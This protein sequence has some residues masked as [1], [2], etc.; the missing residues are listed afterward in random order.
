[1]FLVLELARESLATGSLRDYWPAFERYGTDA[2]LPTRGLAAV[3]WIALVPLVPVVA[4]RRRRLVAQALEG[5]VRAVVA[6]VEVST[7]M[8]RGMEWLECKGIELEQGR[9]DLERLLRGFL[10]SS[11]GDWPNEPAGEHDDADST[12]LGSGRGGTGGAGVTLELL[13]RRGRLHEE[14]VE[15][16]TRQRPGIAHDD[17]RGSR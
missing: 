16:I 11:L 5:V 2:G 3:V 7:A 13:Q 10:S 9:A 1:M 12:E 6:G 4:A 14:G 8:Q 17:R 15:R